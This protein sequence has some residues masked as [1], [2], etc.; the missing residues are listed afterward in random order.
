MELKSQSVVISEFKS[1]DNHAGISNRITENVISSILGQAKYLLT[2]RGSI[3]NLSVDL[4]LTSS[5]S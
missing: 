2:Q 3:W 1:D 4:R 5:H